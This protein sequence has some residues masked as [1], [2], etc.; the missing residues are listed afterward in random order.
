MNNNKKKQI[1]FLP[2]YSPSGASSRYRIY[3]FLPYFEKEGISCVVS[4]LFDDQYFMRFNE[5]KKQNIF[6]L[7]TC[8]LRRFVILF[9]IKKYDLVFIQYELF[10]YFPFSLDSWFKKSKTKY[11]LDFDDAIFHNYDVIKP[12]FISNLFKNKFKNLLINAEFVI[13]GSP[14]LTEYC[15]TFSSKVLEIP[16]VLAIDKYLINDNKIEKDFV[17]GWIGSKSTSKYILDILPALV[18]FSQLNICIIHLIGFD[19]SIKEINELKNV[20]LIDWTENTEVEEINKFSVGIMP[21]RDTNWE[22]GKCGFKLIQYMALGK[23][24]IATP[25]KANLKIDKNNSGLY[26]ITNEEW[27]LRLKEIFKE[28]EKYVE[29][30]HQNRKVIE[31]NYS[32]NSVINQYLNILKI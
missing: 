1:L 25:L 3:Q 9:S 29:V 22:N 6:H 2:K 28:K 30:G 14:Y 31:L 12:K 7:F 13:T 17:I 32:I 19:K 18:E 5:G 23:P 26:A 15:N 16:T 8:Y 20:K 24:T 11:V 21:L 10:P 27:V 4:P